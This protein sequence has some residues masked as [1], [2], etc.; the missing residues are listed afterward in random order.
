VTS[1]AGR[2]A[3]RIGIRPSI[4]WA[5]FRTAVAAALVLGGLCAPTAA[6]VA[7]PVASFT[8]SPAQPLV[9]QT[10]T[11]TSTS[12]DID[13]DI[14]ALDWDLDND[15]Q[16]DDGSGGTAQL[17]FADAGPHSVRLQVT[18]ATG[19]SAVATEV[20][21]VNPLPNLRPQAGFAV[22]PARPQIG[23][24]VSFQ[25]TSTD[26]VGIAATAWDL[27]NDG[28]FDDASGSTATHTFTASGSYTVRI[29]VRDAA[30]EENVF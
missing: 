27:D 9:G 23:Q 5:R 15:G 6:A 18:D 7:P 11:F 21:S 24:R 26:D 28:Q 19:G 2:L 3:C 4:R 20:V 22:S 30:G 17:P 16:F 8:F 14:V 10:I 25:S 13:G 1:A 12:T 29:M